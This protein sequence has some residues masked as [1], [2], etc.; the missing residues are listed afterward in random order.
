MLIDAY[1]LFHEGTL[2]LEEAESNGFLIDS[3]YY[4]KHAKKYKQEAEQI[5]EEIK[6]DDF[7]EPWYNHY[8]DKMNVN[9]T[10]QLSWFLYGCLKLKPIKE[11]D[12]G[13][14]S[15]D[16]DVLSKLAID[17]LKPLIRLRK[18]EKIRNTYIKSFLREQ[19]DNR[20]HAD[21]NLHIPATYRS[22]CSSPN[23]QNIPIRDPE[24][25][26]VIRGG[27]R[28]RPGHQ[29]IEVDY[30]AIEVAISAVYHKDPNMI[31]YIKDPTTDMHKDTAI[32][33]FLLDALDKSNKN[34]SKIRGETK[35][36]FVFP[37]F[38]GSFYG[39]CAPELW[40]TA[41][42]CKLANGLPLITHL[43]K[44]GIRK[45]QQFE[46]HVKKAEDIF[47]N[48][49]F[50]VYTEWKKKQWK[51]FQKMGYLK[52]K[53]GFEF[54]T[55][56]ND[57]QCSNYPIQGTAFHCLLWSFIQVHKFIKAKRLNSRLIGQVHDSMILDVDP[58]ERDYLL[59]YIKWVSTIK[60]RKEF[61][62]I[63]VPLKVEAEGAGIDEPWSM[64]KDIEI[65]EKK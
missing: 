27:I 22:S 18:I 25:G 37:E 42:E 55:I 63:N 43:R 65:K 10:D 28:P 16:K 50:A 49:R 20:I 7:F 40:N 44:K 17:E 2:A 9:S 57:R 19:W 58:V 12:A 34:E 29:I 5:L 4:K 14:N 1:N 11:S 61:S 62:W 52:T 59:R 53:I 54:K 21:Y 6:E 39:S 13:N 51:R 64:K 36:K 46:N 60:I 23:L 24:I 38:Y 56:M 48:E 30:G 41:R 8:K 33:I 3:T 31:L 32:D 15:V 47:W 45:Y 35:N 26:T